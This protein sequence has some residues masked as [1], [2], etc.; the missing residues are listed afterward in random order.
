MQLY[1][2]IARTYEGE[3]A[4]F[5]QL[6]IA[7]ILGMHHLMSRYAGICTACIITCIGPMGCLLVQIEVFSL[8]A[9]SDSRISG[10]NLDAAMQ[11]HQQLHRTHGHGERCVRV[12]HK[13][14]NPTV[15]C[16]CVCVCAY[17][18]ERGAG[19]VLQKAPVI[20]PHTR[21]QKRIIY[22]PDTN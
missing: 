14:A 19:L 22:S 5:P 4:V 11:M 9:E 20:P 16:M 1:D 10:Q 3:P 15:H 6:G 17:A 8:I 7:H 12:G 18:K 13:R 21:T 2:K